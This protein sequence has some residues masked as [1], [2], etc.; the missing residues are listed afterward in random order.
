VI[1]HKKFS[2]VVPVYY[3]AESLPSLAESLDWLESELATRGVELEL[4]FVNDGSPDNSQTELLRIKQRRPQT[5]VISHTR[6]FG[7]VAASRTGFRFV[8]GD[9]FLVL[10]ADLQDPVET[11]L[12][13]ID[14]WLLGNSFIIGVRRTRDDPAPSALFSRLYYKL[15]NAFILKGY[16]RSGF[17]L[18]LAERRVLEF[19]LAATKNVN[20]NIFAYS[21]GFH[22]TVIEYD[23]RARERGKSRWSFAKKARHFVN[24][25]T[26]FSAVPI[27]FMSVFGLVISA[28]SFLYGGYM[29]TASFL[30]AISV[31]GFTTIVVLISFFFGLTLLTLGII[32]EYLWRI[33]EIVNKNVESVTDEVLL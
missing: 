25:I 29:A 30:G 23:R 17:D 20:P 22:P 11:V 15:I 12:Q 9:A 6:N 28:I 19:I 7:A 26:G 1:T 18:M 31:A 10:A 16:P 14:S 8:T 21:L 5:K 32:G 3:N 4:I 2:V 33:F 24:T 13:M 27:R